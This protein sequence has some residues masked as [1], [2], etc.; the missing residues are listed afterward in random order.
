MSNKYLGI[1]Q[2]IPLTSNIEHIYPSECLIETSEKTAKALG[3]QITTLDKTRLQRKMGVVSMNDM[4]KL[5]QAILIQLG[6][7]MC[8]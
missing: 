3:S 1:V 4:Q 8:S 7:K 5:E 2:V 6:L